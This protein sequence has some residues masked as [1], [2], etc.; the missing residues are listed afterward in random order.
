MLEKLKAKWDATAPAREK[1]AAFFNELRGD[2]KLVKDSPEMKHL[3]IAAF[4]CGVVGT[5][6]AVFAVR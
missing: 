5:L 4:V 6:V 2:F 1:A 3:L